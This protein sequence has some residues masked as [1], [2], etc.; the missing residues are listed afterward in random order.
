MNKNI[1][2]CINRYIID[3]KKGIDYMKKYLVGIALLRFESELIEKSGVSKERF[4]KLSGPQAKDVY[5][6]ICER[7]ADKSK[8]YKNGLHWANINGYSK[9]SMKDFRGSYPV[10]YT[11]WYHQLTNI[12]PEK[13]MVYFLIDR[14]G[15]YDAGEK[16]WI[17][18]SYVKDLIQTLD[19]LNQTAFLDIGWSDYYIVSKKYEWLIGF[20]HHDVVSFIGKSLNLSGI[21]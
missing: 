17:F 4:H 1:Y 18:E 15:F 21:E 13:N 10:N 11:N 3:K 19:L 7:Y 2:F 14:G 6:K 16:F 9:K 20:N 12:I 8:T 5:Y